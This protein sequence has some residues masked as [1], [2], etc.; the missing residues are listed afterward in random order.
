MWPDSRLAS[1]LDIEQGIGEGFE[2][3]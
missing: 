3:A 1:P 2:V